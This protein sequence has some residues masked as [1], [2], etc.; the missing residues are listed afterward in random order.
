MMPDGSKSFHLNNSVT[1]SFDD[2]RIYCHSKG[3]I[4]ATLK[5]VDEVAFVMGLGKKNHHS[6]QLEV[7]V[8]ENFFFARSIPSKIT[9]RSSMKNDKCQIISN[10][11]MLNYTLALRALQILKLQGSD[12]VY[13]RKLSCQNLY[14]FDTTHVANIF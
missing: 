12:M 7:T 4:L 10:K 11:V 8:V 14:P 9:Q 2:A 13:T 6:S 1:L 5:T 3:G